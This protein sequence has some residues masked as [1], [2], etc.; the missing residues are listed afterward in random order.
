LLGRFGQASLR[1]AIEHRD[2]RADD[3]EVA[4]FLGRDVEQHVLASGILFADRLRE[5]THRG[6]QLALGTAELFEQQSSG[7]QSHV[8]TAVPA[9]GPV[10]GASAFRASEAPRL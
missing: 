3:F 6:G 5:V 4:Q 8:A 10:R 2:Q 1:A 9:R 7:R